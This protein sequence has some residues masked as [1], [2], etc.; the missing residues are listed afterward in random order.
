MGSID[1]ILNGL[2]N[3]M[4]SHRLYLPVNR[5][6]RVTS[7]WDRYC[8]YRAVQK[9]RGELRTLSNAQLRDIGISRVEADNEANKAGFWI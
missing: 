1:T 5:G 6:S 8:A 9:S 7:L 4:P 2:R 3:T